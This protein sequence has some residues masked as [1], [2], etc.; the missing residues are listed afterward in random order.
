MRVQLRGKLINRV[1][2]GRLNALRIVKHHGG[3]HLKGRPRKGVIVRILLLM[4]SDLT[5]GWLARAL[6]IGL[7][8]RYPISQTRRLPLFAG[9]EC[10]RRLFEG[11][12]EGRRFVLDGRRSLV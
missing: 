3:S 2:G 1:D 12:V 10:V 9:V 7:L 4:F 11:A 6:R 8:P 5:V